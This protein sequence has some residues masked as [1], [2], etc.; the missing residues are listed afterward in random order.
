[1]ERCDNWNFAA[2]TCSGSW[3]NVTDATINRSA[4][5]FRVR[6]NSFSA[7]GIKQFLAPP[8]IPGAG[9]A[10]GGKSPSKEVSIL[11][12][13]PVSISVTPGSSFVLSGVAKNIGN[14]PIRD[15]HITLSN[16]PADWQLVESA[17]ISSLEVDERVEFYLKVQTSSCTLEGDY[18]ATFVASIGDRVI[19]AANTTITV[20]GESDTKV[21]ISLDTTKFKRILKDNIQ[22]TG[23]IQNVGSCPV[24]GTILFDVY[25]SRNNHVARLAEK[26]ISIQPGSAV[27]IT[28]L[29]IVWKVPTDIVAGEYSIVGT[30]QTPHFQEIASSSVVIDI[31]P[32]P[33]TYIVIGT[34][35]FQ[36]FLIAVV[37]VLIVFLILFWPRIKKLS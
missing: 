35:V 23:T 8:P 25:D 37:I 27:D 24:D 2:Q 4:N 31:T 32:P 6:V 15:I 30:Y 12:L 28:E 13:T 21:A 20:R 9:G 18:L 36:Y 1:L 16:L 33:T 17:D 3:V 34:P 11:E 29:D 26:Q 22:L 10:G 14:I 5:F 7:F 19:G